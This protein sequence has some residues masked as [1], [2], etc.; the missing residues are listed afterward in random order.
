[1]M[2]LT[3][4]KLGKQA[5]VGVETIRYYQRRGLLGV[6]ERPDS[7]GLGGGVR[8]YGEEDVQR[9]KFIRSAKLAGFTLEEIGALLACDPV[10]DRPS[11]LAL[12]ERRIA[13]IDEQI[14]ILNAA[15]K[16]LDRLARQCGSGS[17]GACP[18]V[19]AFGS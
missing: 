19:E 15:R 17:E 4:A 18:I 12:A 11:I 3:I 13:A 9:L 5:G 1:M 10:A 14:D 2:S 6:P 8:R 7:G 16:S